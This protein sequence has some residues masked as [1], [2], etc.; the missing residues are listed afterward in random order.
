MQQ[1]ERASTVGKRRQV[2]GGQR[3]DKTED[4]Q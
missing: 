3:G 2:E 4:A 1:E